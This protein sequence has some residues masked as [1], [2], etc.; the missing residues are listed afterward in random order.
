MNQK[1]QLYWYLLHRS[2]SYILWGSVRLC[3]V[4]KLPVDRSK[5]TT[6][7]VHIGVTKRTDCG[8]LIDPK[9]G[10]AIFQVK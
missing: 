8:E 10:Q 7:S 9:I 6:V 3:N 1:S 2:E 5:Y 4:G